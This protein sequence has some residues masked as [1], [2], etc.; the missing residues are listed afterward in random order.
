MIQKFMIGK[1]KCMGLIN[2]SFINK[3]LMFHI[4]LFIGISHFFIYFYLFDLCL[5]I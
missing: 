4:F 5:I 1:W 2:N 3:Y